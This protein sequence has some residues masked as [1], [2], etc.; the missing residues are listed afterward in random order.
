VWD[1]GRASGAGAARFLTR[2]FMRNDDARAIAKRGRDRDSNS[3]SCVRREYWYI[4]MTVRSSSPPR[5]GLFCPLRDSTHNPTRHDSRPR[6]RP[7]TRPRR[8]DVSRR[9]A[10]AVR[11]RASARAAPPRLS[12]RRA[13]RAFA[14]SRPPPGSRA[15]H[16]RRRRRF[17]PGGR[18]AARSEAMDAPR[19]RRVRGRPRRRRRRGEGGQPKAGADARLA[20]P[21]RISFAARLSRRAPQNFC[22]WRVRR[23]FPFA[24]RRIFSRARSPS[25]TNLPSSP[26]A[27]PPSRP[28]SSAG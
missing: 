2:P 15:R 4:L 26:L 9:L 10:R 17:A 6:A 12:S 23:I 5:R 27:P 16:D 13:P 8:R 22:R 3:D 20:P 7:V 11:L 14:S 24:A 18:R 21:R 25:H 1:D 19:R 28:L